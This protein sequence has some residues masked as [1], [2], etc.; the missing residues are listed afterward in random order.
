MKKL[1]NNNLQTTGMRNTTFILILLM[2]LLQPLRAQ[3]FSLGVVTDYN[4][5]TELDSI[6][7]LM[8]NQIDQTL[9][10]LRNIDLNRENISFDNVTQE[11]AAANYG[12]IADKTDLVILIG[13]KSIKGV[14]DNGQFPV[15]TFGIGVIDP[16]I[17][18]IQ[19]SNG[20]SGIPN[21]TYI[22]A[23]NG[24]EKNLSEFKKLVP[25]EHLTILANPGT[26][27]SLNSNSGNQGMILMEEKLM[28]GIQTLEME[29]DIAA[30]LE[31]LNPE[32][33]AVY[34]SDLGVRKPGEIRELAK[35]LIEKKLPSF[36]G[37]K[38]HVYDGIF[39]CL[40]HD[41]SF[42]QL[43]RKLGI[44]VDEALSG[45]PLEEME[46]KT[47]YSESLFINEQTA[48]AI[49]LTLPFEVLFAAKT[50]KANDGVPVYSLETIIEL[51]FNNNLNI[52]MSKQDVELALEEVKAARSS[53]LPNLDLSLNARQINNE[54]ANAAADNPERKI[55]GRLQLD[56]MI[57]SQRA[58]ASIK[59]AKYYQKAQE[60]LTEADILAVMFNTFNDYLE[61]LSAKSVL[62]IEQE[63]LENMEI[64]L[65]IAKL[66]VESGALSRT[67]LY[68]W[69]S[70]VALA[71]QSVVVA[72]TKLMEFKFK[73]NNRLAFVLE[74][75]FD[76]EDISVDDKIYKQ[77]REG[78]MSKQVVT[79]KD[80]LTVSDFLV[81][82]AMQSNPN[83]KSIVE[84]INALERQRKQSKGLLY[85]PDISL[86]AQTTQ[87]FFRDGIGSQ[88]IA[89]SEFIDNTWSVGVGLTYP[90]F[91]GSARR[92]DLRISTIQLDQLNNSRTQLD[93]DLE[94]AIR[95]SLLNV[96]SASTNIDYSK[97]AS[98]N[99]E[100]NFGLIQL[101]YGEGDVDI[102]QLIDAQR[103][104]LQA[105][106][107]YAVSVYDYLRSQLSLQYAVGFFPMVSSDSKVEEFR[108][109][110]L[111]Y[112]N[113]YSNE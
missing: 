69:E 34:I 85:S 14:Y 12:N 98:E 64:N 2:I 48:S 36:S 4:Q 82:E 53:V 47:V 67:E 89:G 86:Q 27:L 59:I 45:K 40:A 97:I 95:S 51:A 30:S 28:A 5:T 91:A 21:F 88:E 66:Q 17:Q 108:N 54:S 62:T 75:E 113:K 71:K 68:R 37:E 90:I 15:P 13:G 81:E 63:N 11:K 107:R 96:V 18:G 106:L 32:T 99:A 61:I 93:N 10:S 1:K 73:L 111:L 83:K 57:Y 109:R 100:N 31:K 77:F 103:A 55:N 6:L 16:V 44:M 42:A 76:I 87:V 58:I 29:N 52:V 23:T 24:L 25:F 101:R 56:Q 105:K 94:L 70:E 33:D 38:S 60:Y 26:A 74:K 41:N 19:Y 79:A 92:T 104:A 8:V 35:L 80:I 7:K 46:V 43:L 78:F 49:N 112:K 72:N 3:D 9:G 22:W 50:V 20:K 102:T 39:A 110:F 65:E 84:Q